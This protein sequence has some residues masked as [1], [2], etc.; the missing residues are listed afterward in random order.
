MIRYRNTVRTDSRIKSE[1]YAGKYSLCAVQFS[2]YILRSFFISAFLGLSQFFISCSLLEFIYI[3]IYFN[4]AF[5]FFNPSTADIQSFQSL[6]A[7]P[8]VQMPDHLTACDR[9]SLKI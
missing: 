2:H 1:K 4:V 5:F 8:H 3:Y 6:L 9:D 7:R